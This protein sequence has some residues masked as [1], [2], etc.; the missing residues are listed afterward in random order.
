MSLKDA[1]RME[2]PLRKLCRETARLTFLSRDIGGS[3][4][5]EYLRDELAKS[6]GRICEIAL[7]SNF[8]KSFKN[9]DESSA[10]SIGTACLEYVIH[11]MKNSIGLQMQYPLFSKNSKFVKTGIHEIKGQPNNLYQT[12]S[13]NIQYLDESKVDKFKVEQERFDC[14]RK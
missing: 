4:D 11:V 1:Q 5:G 8:L 10:I 12:N 7:N 6:W 9:S 14:F 3:G 2:S 13:V